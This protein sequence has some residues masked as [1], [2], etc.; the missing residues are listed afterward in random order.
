MDFLFFFEKISI[1]LAHSRQNASCRL[2]SCEKPTPPQNLPET[3]SLS[4]S[5]LGYYL[6]LVIS[7]G[8]VEIDSNR[9]VVII[10][11]WGKLRRTTTNEQAQFQRYRTKKKTPFLGPILSC[12]MIDFLIGIPLVWSNRVIVNSKEHLFLCS[13][14]SF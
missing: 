9:D 1:A 10:S 2:C 12:W 11:F 6:L 14:D 3:Y 7:L 13:S 5:L 8:S 4:R